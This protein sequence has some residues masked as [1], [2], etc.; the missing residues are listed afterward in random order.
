[1]RVSR[2]A[3]D[4][5]QAPSYPSLNLKPGTVLVRDWGGVTH[6]AMVLEDGILFRSKRTNHF[7][8]SHVLSPARSGTLDAS[9]DQYQRGCET[10][11]GNARLIRQVDLCK[12]TATLRGLSVAEEVSLRNLRRDLRKKYRAADLG[13]MSC[14][15]RNDALSLLMRRGDD[16]RALSHARRINWNV[17]GK[18]T[19]P[20][21]LGTASWCFIS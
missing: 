9:G 14:P 10:D 12:Q 18:P 7:S 1:M 20:H 13:M 21:P 3:A 5:R 11:R 15:S 4:G 16:S 17:I 6:Q 8:R 19:A 2:D